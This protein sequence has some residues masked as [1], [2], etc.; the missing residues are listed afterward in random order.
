ML[1]IRF[2]REDPDGFDAGLARRGLAPIAAELLALD[3]EHR[4]RLGELQDMQARRNTASKAIGKAKATGNEDEAKALMA[5]VADLKA[6]MPNVEADAKEKG[7]A[8]QRQLAAL[9]NI[10]S[11][12][13]P[14][15][16]D[17]SAN[18]ELRRWGTPTELGFAGKEHDDIGA[19]LGMDFEAAA[20]MSGARFVVLRGQIA[21]LERALG[22]F[23]LDHQVK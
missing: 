2:L 18:E 11:G 7:E 16:A 6:T 3:A 12:D 14:M 19:P 21:R 4:A 8:V 17:E 9:P 13:V 10:P 1:D 22:Q 20:K 15:G 23:M 5:E